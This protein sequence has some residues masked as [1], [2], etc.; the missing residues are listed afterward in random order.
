MPTSAHPAPPPYSRAYEQI[1]GTSDDVVG[2]VGYAL[3]KKMIRGRLVEGK[4]V[5]ASQDRSLTPDEV[6]LYRS[7]AD[8]YLQLFAAVAVDTARP[9]ILKDAML[10]EVRRATGFWNSL[11]VGV[12][13]WLA[14]IVITIL[15]TYA[16]PDW[17]HAV[18]AHLAPPK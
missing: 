1:I 3:Y 6:D 11:V 16:A 8:A 10:D 14:S 9:L 7:K 15:V 18:V 13:A 5:P 4:L 17:T 2:L 12:V